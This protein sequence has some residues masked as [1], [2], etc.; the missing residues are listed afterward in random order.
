[1]RRS[2]AI[3]TLLSF[4][5]TSSGFSQT[6]VAPVDTASIQTN[7]GGVGSMAAGSPTPSA[8]TA[9]QGPQLVN[10]GISLPSV[11]KPVLDAVTP[12]KADP[13]LPL[14]RN[15]ITGVETEKPRAAA[16]L[17]EDRGAKSALSAPEEARQPEA[18][19]ARDA[20]NSL[21]DVPDKQDT[22]QT[23]AHFQARAGKGVSALCGLSNRSRQPITRR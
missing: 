5:L 17:K 11:N 13:A 8:A 6:K 20:L 18:V 15:Q 7:I 23:A 21:A 3:V 4:L 12:A 16:S 9:M 1:M 2:I 14:I 10:N 22:G 19:T